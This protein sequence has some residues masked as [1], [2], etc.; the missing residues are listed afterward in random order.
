[1]EE[2]PIA[3][4]DSGV[5]GLTVIK[6]VIK[7]L[8]SE[9]LVYLGDTARVPYGPRDPETITQ[10]S[11]QMLKFLIKEN[12]KAILVACN[13]ITATCLESLQAVSP[14]P[15]IGIIEPT[16]NYAVKLTKTNHIG[17]IAT[18]ATIKSGVYEQDIHSMHFDTALTTQ[19]CPLF[20]PL[21]EENWIDHAATKLIIEEYLQPF[22]NTTVDTLILGCT[23]YPI[24]A[25]AIQEV[26]GPKVRLINSAI[27]TTMAIKELLETN[28]LLRKEGTP[29]YKFYITG[30][31]Y[32]AE[33]TA[34]TFF[35]H[36]FPG[37]LEKVILPTS[38][39]LT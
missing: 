5:G 14:V 20:V 17:V 3:I 22:K 27:P 37:K 32:I 2:R 24:L 34:R 4:F 35:N 15:V 19:A 26:V 39:T 21:V 6:E 13:T 1:M 9:N 23:H 33:K 7:Q 38:S 18:R 25:D 28:G 30:A 29:N 10:F 12:P 11:M 36:D 8:P 31:P 16:I